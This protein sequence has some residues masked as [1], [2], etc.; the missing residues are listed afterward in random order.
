MGWYLG[1]FPGAKLVRNE[2]VRINSLADVERIIATAV[3]RQDEEG[4][5]VEDVQMEEVGDAELDVACAC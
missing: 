2:L 5:G 3:E 1:H 4:E